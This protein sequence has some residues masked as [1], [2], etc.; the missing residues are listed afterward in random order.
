[1]TKVLTQQEVRTLLKERGR[2]DDYIEKLLHQPSCSICGRVFT[3]ERPEKDAFELDELSHQLVEAQAEEYDVHLIV[4]KRKSI[5]GKILKL[6]ARTNLVYVGNESGT[7]RIA[8][9]D[10]LKIES[11]DGIVHECE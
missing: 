4:W 5:I 6:D 1:M 11:P 9:L 8:F 10:I 3:R 2:D 7:H